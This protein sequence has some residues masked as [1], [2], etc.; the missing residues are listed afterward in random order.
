M[1]FDSEYKPFFQPPSWII[2]PIWMFL[3][4]CL[5]I[6]F[7][8]TLSKKDQLENLNLIFIAFL[9]Q[10]VMIFTWPFVF[11]SEKY[12]MSLFMIIIM[13]I[14]TLIYVFLTYKVVPVASKLVLPYL[15]WISFAGIINIAY[16]LEAN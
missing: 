6:S 14:F 1:T 13:I 9:I 10:I 8:N 15:L 3:Y 11:N 2:G 7:T 4:V 5:A 12:L 16:Y